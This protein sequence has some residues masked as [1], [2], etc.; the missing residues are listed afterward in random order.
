AIARSVAGPGTALTLHTRRNE[1]GLNAVA[2]AARA[3]GSEVSTIFVDLTESGAG[4]IVAQSALSAFGRIDQIVS[5][6]GFAD[7]RRVGEFSLADFASAHAAITLAFLELADTALPHLKTSEWG[8]VVA[9]SSFVA[10]TFGANDVVFPTTAAAKGGLE[11]LAKALAYQLAPDGVTVN[12]VAPGY[13]RKDPGAHQ[14]VTGDGW[15]LAAELAPMKTLVAPD[16]VAAAVQF[17][18]SRGAAR[19]TGQVLHVDAGLGLL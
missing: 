6:A 10:H 14:G 15:R 3:A 9:I 8:R 18:L 19:I 7:K 4:T 5:N 17:L 2:T 16:D 12:C 11:A 1:E 13:T